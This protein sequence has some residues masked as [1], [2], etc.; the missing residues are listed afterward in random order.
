MTMIY[1]RATNIKVNMISETVFF[2]KGHGVHSAFLNTVDLLK[3]K[4]VPFTINSLHHAQVT[5][6]Q[7]IGLFSLFMLL[8]NKPS[9]ISAH[10]VPLSLKDSIKGYELWGN[11]AKRYLKTFYNKGDIILAVSPKVKEDLI[12]LGVTKKIE[13]FPNP[14]NIHIF[15]KDKKLRKK[16]REILNASSNDMIIL[17][18]GQIQQRK[19]IEEFLDVAKRLPQYK[20]IWIGGTPFKKLNDL[21]ENLKKS[22]YSAP[23]I[24]VTGIQSYSD[25]PALLNAGDMLFF[26]SHQENASMA[27]IEA[28]ACNLPIILRNLPEYESLYGKN[29]LSGNTIGEFEILIKKLSTNKQFYTNARKKSIALAKRFTFPTLANDLINYYHSVL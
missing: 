17:G 24:K 15:K 5:H 20:F 16:G 3:Y 25:M 29:Y 12:R 22:F 8:L 27:I 1:N 7:T 21:D 10:I 11:I 26:P 18:V 19:G 14:V 6:I 13:I 28:A 4:K 9:V 23:N 2:P